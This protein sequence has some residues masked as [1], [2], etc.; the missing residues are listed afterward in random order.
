MRI[1]L[2]RS[3]QHRLNAVNI[4]GKLRYFMPH[5]MARRISRIWERLVHPIIYP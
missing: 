4:Y 2:H 5:G 1:R 3:L